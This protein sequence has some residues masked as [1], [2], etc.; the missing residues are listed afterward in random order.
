MQSGVAGRVQE[1]DRQSKLEVRLRGK[2]K[3]CVWGGRRG[4][5]DLVRGGGRAVETQGL[6]GKRG[7][8]VFLRLG[9]RYF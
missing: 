3:V 8:V 5:R 7:W 1:R 9:S 6:S 4:E 2:G